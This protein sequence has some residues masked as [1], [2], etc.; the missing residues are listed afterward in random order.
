MD[1]L[2]IGDK[3]EAIGSK[4]LFQIDRVVN[5]KNCFGQSI[6]WY[7]AI[8]LSLKHDEIRIWFHPEQLKD[9]K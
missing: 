6:I 2:N 8:D 4:K 3:I 7:K 1:I 5:L 9:N